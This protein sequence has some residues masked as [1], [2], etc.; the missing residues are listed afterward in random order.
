MPAVD[1]GAGAEEETDAFGFELDREIG[2]DLLRDYPY[3]WSDPASVNQIDRLQIVDLETYFEEN[4]GTDRA[5]VITTDTVGQS[6]LTALADIVARQSSHDPV[7]N[8]L[9]EPVER[10]LDLPS[11]IDGGVVVARAVPSV[12]FE[13]WFRTLVVDRLLRQVSE[14]SA[15]FRFRPGVDPVLHR[16]EVSVAIPLFAEDVRDNLLDQIAQMQF[17]NP[18]PTVLRR[19]VESAPGLSGASV[20]ARMVR[21]A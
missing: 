16:I 9:S 14:P 6:S 1:F 7:T 3:I 10:V 2:T 12:H 8:R 11:R 13:D 5:Y 18:D 15:R 19:A 17:R 21:G 20:D 4:F